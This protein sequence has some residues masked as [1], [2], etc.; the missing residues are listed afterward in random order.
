[1]G[2][3]HELNDK[4]SGDTQSKSHS[5]G[6]LEKEIYNLTSRM[7][8]VNPEVVGQLIDVV[9]RKAVAQATRDVN[10]TLNKEFGSIDDLAKSYQEIQPAQAQLGDIKKHLEENVELGVFIDS[11]N[12]VQKRQGGAGGTNSDQKSSEEGKEDEGKNEDDQGAKAPTREARTSAQIDRDAAMLI[13]AVPEAKHIIGALKDAA[14]KDGGDVADIYFEN[15]DDYDPKI[16]LAKLRNEKND[17][18]SE[19]NSQTKKDVDTDEDDEDVGTHRIVDKTED[20][21]DV[22]EPEPFGFDEE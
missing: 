14:M 3:E 7:E 2:K 15:R 13:A 1:M 8:G 6:D 10:K 17:D 16:E 20:G 12:T 21:L 5:L 22:Y 11:N 18:T 19:S 9:G 4:D